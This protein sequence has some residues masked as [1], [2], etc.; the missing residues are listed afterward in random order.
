MKLPLS[1]DILNGETTHHLRE[2]P[3]VSARRNSSSQQSK[4]SEPAMQEKILPPANSCS[5]VST[6][7]G[8]TGISIIM[9]HSADNLI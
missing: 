6:P 7:T 5:N 2:D 8:S 9:S 3:P 4:E 1:E